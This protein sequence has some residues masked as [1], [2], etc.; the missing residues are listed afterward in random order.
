M[1][2]QRIFVCVVKGVVK[3]W[4]LPSVPMWVQ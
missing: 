2:I 3:P 1:K 4:L